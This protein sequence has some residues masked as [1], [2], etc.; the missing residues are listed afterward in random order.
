M[1]THPQDTPSVVPF[2]AATATANRF[3][4]TRERIATAA[5]P[6]LRLPKPFTLYDTDVPGL[7]LR[8][9]KGP[10][11][12]FWL[13]KRV[14]GRLWWIRLAPYTVN[15]DLEA[16]RSQAR[17][18]LHRLYAG[19]YEAEAAA[20]AADAA[21]GVDGL[22]AETLLEATE[23]Y[24][25]AS[26]P[27]LRQG[28]RDNYRIASRRL[29]K[30]SGGLF[31]KT[32]LASL[33]PADVRTA[34]DD[35]CT[36]VS[37][38][39]ASGYMRVARAVV[40]GWMASFPEART[41]PFNVVTRGMKQGRKSRW[42]TAPP[43]NRA[44]KPADVPAFL[45]AANSLAIAAKPN[46]ATMFRLVAFLTLTGLRFAEAAELEW[47]EVDLADGSLLIPAHRMKA[48]KPFRK[49]LGTTAVALLT[50][51]RETTST[52]Q[53]AFPSPQDPAIAIDDAR[54]AM[55]AICRRAGVSVSPHDLRRTYIRAA[56][57][58]MLPTAR[59]K[60]LVAHS[61]GKDVTDG[62]V[63]GLEDNPADDAQKVEDFLTGGGK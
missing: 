47:S 30:A 12:T 23:R 56:A 42:V 61:L 48:K 60:S 29:A 58:S 7:A 20:R 27:P 2:K 52:G 15:C 46:R 37:P 38:Q 53:F 13:Q 19:T 41:P 3:R 59:I 33:T 26:Q 44:L 16:L 36:E 32:P 34:Y 14:S 22:L 25:T 21:A 11:L 55:A 40:E 1:P 49:P 57:R 5:R 28:T 8:R 4:F 39:T 31:A 43:R 62:Y 6:L 35:L 51:Q 17:D 24:L 9:Q 18:I 50:A 63:G 10:T 54:T 45:A